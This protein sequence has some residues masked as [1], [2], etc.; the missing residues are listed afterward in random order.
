M[1]DGGDRHIAPSHHTGR[2]PVIDVGPLP[3][4]TR[5]SVPLFMTGALGV[6]LLDRRLSIADLGV[7]RSMGHGHNTRDD[8]ADDNTIARCRELLGNEAEGL[9]DEEIDRVRRHADAVA[10]VIAEMFLDQRAEEESQL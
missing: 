2:V 4:S 7:G 1:T 8:I 9:S 5:P 6:Q 3:T 10:H